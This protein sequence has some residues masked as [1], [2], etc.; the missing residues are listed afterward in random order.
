[1]KNNSVELL[2]EEE[3]RHISQNMIDVSLGVK[4]HNAIPQILENQ[5][6]MN[7]IKMIIKDKE[8]EIEYMEKQYPNIES[9]EHNLHH[10]WKAKLDDVDMFKRLL[11]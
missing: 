9:E 4:F 5:I 6:L 11:L 7:R 3:L 10:E 1:M 2:T 8:N